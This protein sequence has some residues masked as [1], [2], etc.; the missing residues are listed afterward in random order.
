MD[1]RNSILGFILTNTLSFGS[2]LLSCYHSK[3]FLRF[4]GNMHTNNIIFKSDN[5]T[6][7]KELLQLLRVIL[8]QPIY[9]KILGVVNVNMTLVPACVALIISYTVVALQFNNVV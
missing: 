4:I 1:A 5:N 2:I 6:E 7:Q 9:I 8:N 3:T